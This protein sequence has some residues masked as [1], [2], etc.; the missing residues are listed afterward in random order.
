MKKTVYTCDLCPRE[1]IDYNSEK[2]NIKL[3]TDSE[4][5][6]TLDICLH[7]LATT[8]VRHFNVAGEKA[9]TAFLASLNGT[10]KVKK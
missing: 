6:T 4:D 8:V 10:K 7:C 2:D 5:I 9:S 1:L 3:H